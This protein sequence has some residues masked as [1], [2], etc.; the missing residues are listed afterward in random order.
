MTPAGIDPRGRLVFTKL[1]HANQ[2]RAALYWLVG[3]RV[4]LGTRYH[5]Y[6]AGQPLSLK[7]NVIPGNQPEPTARGPGP[8]GNPCSHGGEPMNSRRKANDSIQ[9]DP[10][11]VSRRLCKK[12]GRSSGFLTK[13]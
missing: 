3:T 2:A 11:L 9:R 8:S 10:W 12:T 7:I 6:Q 5:P 1:Y 13:E 4:L